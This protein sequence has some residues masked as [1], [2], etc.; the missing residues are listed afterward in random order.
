MK[1]DRKQGQLDNLPSS[2]QNANM[3]LLVLSVKN[4]KMAAKTLNCVLGPFWHRDNEPTQ[5]PTQETVPNSRIVHGYTVF[6]ALWS[7]VQQ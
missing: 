7:L 1:D 3:R 5:I 6:L 2:V 4:F